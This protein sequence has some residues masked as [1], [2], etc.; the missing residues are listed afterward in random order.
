MASFRHSVT[1]ILDSGGSCT[2]R[3]KC[4]AG[5]LAGRLTSAGDEGEGAAP[6][7]CA[8]P[9]G[10]KLRSGTRLKPS[11]GPWRIGYQE[12][13]FSSLEMLGYHQPRDSH[14]H[15]RPSRGLTM[16]ERCLTV[17][18]GQTG[19]LLTMFAV[20]SRRH[21]CHS[22]AD[23]AGSIPVTR[24]T[25]K[26]GCS[27]CSGEEFLHCVKAAGSADGGCSTRSTG[28][29]RQGPLP[30]QAW[31]AVEFPDPDADLG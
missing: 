23:S 31:V 5:L 26:S 1:I 6:P 24:F 9:P 15:G 10:P 13:H 29:A 3:V 21:S 18:H 12:R 19:V 8:W 14:I 20:R 17:N 30:H 7:P 25:R 2:P 27:S 28:L 4:P 16:N 11:R 22:Q